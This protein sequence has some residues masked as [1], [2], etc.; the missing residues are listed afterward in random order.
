MATF[1]QS[2]HRELEDEP[3]RDV[4]CS[5]SAEQ[6]T[7][8]VYRC[9]H[10]MR[11]L[12]LPEQ[13][14]AE[15]SLANSLEQRLLGSKEGSLFCD[16]DERGFVELWNASP[17][18]RL[19]GTQRL[20]LTFY[21]DGRYESAQLASEVVGAD[22]GMAWALIRHLQPTGDPDRAHHQLERT[23]ARLCSLGESMRGALNRSID[24]APMAPD[25]SPLPPREAYE[26]PQSDLG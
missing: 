22:N 20:A 13:Q 7:Q 25:D 9:R 6:I 5:V 8:A 17:N 3:V 21:R 4:R 14:Q 15:L 26:A 18:E 11:S 12:L 2:E 1:E 24:H 16:S 10:G 23:F 19:N